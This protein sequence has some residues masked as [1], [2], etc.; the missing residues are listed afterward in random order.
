MTTVAGSGGR[1]QERERTRARER[2]REREREG[3]EIKEGM[4]GSEMYSGAVVTTA[5]RDA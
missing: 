5:H 3:R 4:G 2:M 1:V